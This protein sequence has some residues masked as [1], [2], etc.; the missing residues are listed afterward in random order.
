M[1]SL[2]KEYRKLL[3][4]TV[5]SARQ[6]AVS[7]ARKALTAL[8]VGDKES[9]TDP[10]QKAL[11]AQLRAHGRQL[12]DVRQPDGTQETRRLEQACAY[13][14]W[15]RLLFARFLAENNLLVNPDYG[16][17]MSLSEIQ[18]T[19]R[20]QN[21]DWLSLASDF[22]QRMLLEVFRPDDPV[23]RVMMPP[24]T[25]QE[26]EESLAQLP[27]DVFTCDDSLGWVYQF[28]QRDEKDRVNKSEV[29]IGADE[30]SPVTQLFT[31]DY[32]VLF[33][34]HN[35]LGAWWTAKRRAEGKSSQ[36]PGCE[37]IYLRL[38]DDGSPSA[39][40]HDGWPKT[41][42]ELRLLDPCMGSGHFLTFALQIIARMRQEEEGLTITEAVNR[43]LSDNLFGLEVDP[44]CSQIAAFNLAMTAWR[45]IASPVNLPP[46]RLA[47]SGLGINA[48]HEAW[49][50][51][52]G[53]DARARA[54]LSRLYFLFQEAPLLGSL[55]DP[56]RLE[57]NVFAAGATAVLPILEQALLAEPTNVERAELTVAAKGVLEAFRILS[58]KYTLVITN[59]PYLGRGKQH[60]ILAKYCKEFHSAAKNDLS[61]SFLD[62]SMRFCSPSG[63]IAVVI[64]Q[65]WL[66]QP[67]YRGFRETI[68]NEHQWDFLALLGPNAFQGMNW[69]AATTALLTL[70]N[71]I[72]TQD[73]VI[74]GWD[75][76]HA[77][78]PLDKS[79]A[80][81]SVPTRASIQAH[82]FSN[83]G[84][85]IA[86]DTKHSTTPLKDYASV[87][88][89]SKP[90]ETSRVTAYFWEVEKIDD[91]WVP[92]ESSPSGKDHYSGKAELCLSLEE[93]A[94]QKVEG[95]GVR[96]AEAWGRSGVIIAKMRSL[97]SALYLGQF[98]DHNTFAI[99]PK[100]TDHLG[101]IY[102]FIRQGEFHK[103]IRKLNQKSDITCELSEAIPFELDHW[104]KVASEKYGNG[105][106]IPYSNDATQWLFSGHPVGSNKPLQV[107][108]ARLLGYRWPRQ[109]GSSFPGCEALS[110]DGLDHHADPDGI[111]CLKSLSGE[112]PA[113][114]KLRALLAEAYDSEWS[115]STLA[116]LVGEA[117]SL[118]TWLRDKF[119]Q[120]HCTMFHGR[121]FVW[122]VWDGRKD[123]FHALVNYHKLV[124][125]HGEG[126]RTIEKL[127]YTALGDWISRQQA[128]VDAGI[129]GAEGRLT[130]SKHLRIEL[131]NI[132]NGESPYDIFVR[133]KPLHEQPLGW[134][135]DANDGVRLNMRPWLNT[136]IYQEPGQK[137]KH[138][139]CILR[140]TPIKLPL[141]KDRGKE[142]PRDKID[143]PWCVSSR[144]RSND[145]HL[146]LDQKLTAR[147][148]KQKV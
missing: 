130:A 126:R 21:R 133:W 33:L 59:V 86:F 116:E 67:G 37:W 25:R 123:G 56:S 69:W 119:F 76:S 87:H 54:E 32:M 20:E 48:T 147:D 143:F 106:P 108:V 53:S 148:R 70:T 15:H 125:P 80:L 146:T 115:A 34:L 110:P 134:Q 140:E 27:P 103:L 7:G 14:H 35:T 8:R 109:N 120:E 44:R 121:P 50:E 26:L 66:A 100:H 77:R 81:R 52:A 82:Q 74:V 105:L 136:K 75:V 5:V 2:S 93:I 28:W 97:P 40:S 38:N 49:L 92:M 132:L 129:D 139:S 112:S 16:V 128:E 144:E 23:L 10:D 104:Q 91:R 31:E 113:A 13:E 12:G 39:G 145:V 17:A 1:P 135:P 131:V 18:E 98:F 22:A 96:G 122:H 71:S 19:A 63:S 111:V 95:F 118:E 24:E 57:E 83:P 51:L 47:C 64:P 142:P 88:Y 137:L 89:G 99:I 61:T 9:P 101:A 30:I 6:S 55:V 124:G 102:E 78:T 85:I 36:L 3:E 46:L 141:G 45:M 60:P 107:G 65:N 4:N 73:H 114:D 58:E 138:G 94:R 68:L 42:R 29:K 79:A 41:A 127:I 72:P 90:G 84:A 43:T 62:R 117:G 11:R